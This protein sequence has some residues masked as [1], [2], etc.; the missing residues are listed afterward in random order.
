MPF[1]R[2][3]ESGIEIT[4]KAVPGASRDRI[5]GPLGDALKVQVSAPPEKGKANEA[6]IKLIAETLGIRARSVTVVQGQSAPRK[7]LRVT[8][9]RLEAARAKFNSIK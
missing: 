9:I 5:V 2:E 8:E 3:I 4:I 6:I 1:I 7:I